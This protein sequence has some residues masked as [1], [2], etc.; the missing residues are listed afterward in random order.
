MYQAFKTAK[1]HNENIISIDKDTLRMFLERNG[2]P[3]PI[4]FVD[5]NSIMVRYDLDGD[6]QLNF[7]EFELLLIPSESIQE[8]KE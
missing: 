8:I 4:S 5:L 7:K 6:D 3:S 2:E 1:C